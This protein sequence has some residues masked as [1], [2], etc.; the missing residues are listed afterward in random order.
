[1]QCMPGRDGEE[2]RI[3]EAPFLLLFSTST[4]PKAVQL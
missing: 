2:K 4:P 1:M 3:E